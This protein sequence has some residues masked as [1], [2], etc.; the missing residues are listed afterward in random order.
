M[1][2]LCTLA[3]TAL[4]TRA[5]APIQAAGKFRGLVRMSVNGEYT[6][7]NELNNAISKAEAKL[8][9]ERVARRQLL[10]TSRRQR[11]DRHA[12]HQQARAA[13]P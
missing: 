6:I 4:A 5:A 13:R 1:S 8:A 12:A 3:A 7:S 2:P 10:A 9:A 11:T